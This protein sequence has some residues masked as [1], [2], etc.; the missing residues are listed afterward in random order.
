MGKPI[1]AVLLLHPA[2]VD[3]PAAVQLALVKSVGPRVFYVREKVLVALL[4]F[5]TVETLHY[6]TMYFT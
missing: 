6:R 1:E 3:Q 5:S 2:D 4:N